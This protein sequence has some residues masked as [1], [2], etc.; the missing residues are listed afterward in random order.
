MSPHGWSKKFSVNQDTDK[1]LVLILCLHGET[2]V[3]PN[4]CCPM[5][6]P[7]ETHVV[8]ERKQRRS[9]MVRPNGS[10]DVVAERSTNATTGHTRTRTT[11]VGLAGLASSLHDSK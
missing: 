2:M 7:C 9:T 3:R 11:G 10:R 5:V 4:G 1:T 8:H 6:R